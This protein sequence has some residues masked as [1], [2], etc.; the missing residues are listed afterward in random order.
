MRKLTK[1]SRRVFPRAIRRLGLLASTIIATGSNQTRPNRERSPFGKSHVPHWS[2]IKPITTLPAAEREQTKTIIRGG[3]VEAIRVTPR[4]FTINEDCFE[5]TYLIKKES[6]AHV[7]ARREQAPGTRGYFLNV[8]AVA[9]FEYCE[10]PA[11]L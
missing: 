4:L 7:D 1:R 5:R 6:E 8:F 9:I 11:A 2:T 3:T 10:L